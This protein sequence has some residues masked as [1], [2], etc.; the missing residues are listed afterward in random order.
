VRILQLEV[1][2]VKYTLSY[3]SCGMD[4]QAARES[5]CVWTILYGILLMVGM[6][7]VSC[8]CHVIENLSITLM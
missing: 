3:S 1:A 4:L 7:V 6:M 2:E 5:V 8:D